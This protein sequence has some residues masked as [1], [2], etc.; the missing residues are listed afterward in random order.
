MSGARPFT[1]ADFPGYAEAVRRENTVRAA[2]CLG[3]NEKICGLEVKPLTAYH[4]RWL[5]MVNSPFLL[6]GVSG[7]G[8]ADKPG[9]IDDVMLFL[10]TISPQFKPGSQP[11][12]K[13]KRNLFGSFLFR[14][15]ETNR[16]KFN[17]LFAPIISQRID[18]VCSEIL[19]YVDEA[20]LDY[21]EASGSDKTFYAFE[22]EI[23]HE[24]HEHYGYRV[25]FWNPMPP[26]KNPVHAPLKLIF[27]FRKLRHQAS[28]LVLSNTS[29]R[30]ISKG[31]AEMNE[32]DR[33]QREKN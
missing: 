4:L 6:K 16:D 21:G 10:W 27:Q 25:D 8:L 12:A 17:R 7:E 3:L 30:F 14:I 29:E 9:I 15:F 2:S 18:R 26:E 19:E 1:D 11:S 20:W 33:K 24:M 22:V 28:G 31:L 23:A 32:R 13:W 5:L